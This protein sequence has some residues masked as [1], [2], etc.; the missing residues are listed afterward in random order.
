MYFVLYYSYNLQSYIPFIW[1]FSSELGSLHEISFHQCCFVV[2]YT[3]YDGAIQKGYYQF[4]QQ[5][6]EVK[7]FPIA[8]KWMISQVINV[9]KVG[10]K[11]CVN[12]IIIGIYDCKL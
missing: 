11:I 5:N 6:N 7:A 2:L 8:I 4:I 9:R 3:M 12:R 1:S 10:F